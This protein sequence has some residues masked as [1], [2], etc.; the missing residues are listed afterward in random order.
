MAIQR[1]DTPLASTP[2]PTKTWQQMSQAEKTSKLAELKQ[3]GGVER[4]KQYK[5]SISAD[6]EKRRV[7]AFEKNASVRGMTVE[8][9][10]KDRD[11][12]KPDADKYGGKACAIGKETVGC[13]GSEKASARRVQKEKKRTN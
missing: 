1:K 13:S 10:R 12:K 5:D 8:Q 9:L 11:K 4:V 7:L 6:G 2:D 3:K